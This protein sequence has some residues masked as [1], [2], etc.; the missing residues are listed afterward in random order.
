MREIDFPIIY[1]GVGIDK[2]LSGGGL[3]RSI[4]KEFKDKDT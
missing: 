1:E 2:N 3:R 4:G